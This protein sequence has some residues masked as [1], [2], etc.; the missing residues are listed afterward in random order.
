MRDEIVVVFD[1]IPTK[2]DGGLVA[3]YVD[4]VKE[5]SDSFDITFLSVFRS[6]PS[7]IPAFSTVKT[8]TLFDRELDNRFYKMVSYMRQGNV[9]RFWFAFVSALRYFVSIP[10]AR[11]RTANLLKGK[12]VV[13]VA[14]AAAS[15]LSCNITYILEVH[16]NYE[17]FWGSNILGR[18]QSMLIPAPKVTVFRN[19][20][21]AR[22]GSIKFPSTFMYN[23]F[24]DTSLPQPSLPVQNRFRACFVGRLVE[25][26]NPLLLLGYAEEVC[27]SI[28]EFKLDIYGDGPLYETLANEIAARG[29][30]ACVSLKGFTD[31]KS[32]YQGYDILWLSSRFEGFGLVI[33]EAAA[34]MVPT[35]TT[36]WGPAVYEVIR[37]GETGY[38]AKSSQDFVEKSIQLLS[39]LELRNQFAMRAYDDFHDRFSTSVHKAR[40]IE[41][42]DQVYS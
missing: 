39:N 33:I 35:V 27:K 9:K 5:L 7:D 6:D 25:E 26:K 4:F 23:T 29:L 32:V 15:F 28:P 30:G 11:S 24:D 41:L 17:Y 21:D 18:A 16:A 2:K 12:K 20:D 22:K 19:E 1:K 3:T 34:N 14:P 31:D 40:W 13:A 36:D 38:V 37:N 8:V 42:I 10:F